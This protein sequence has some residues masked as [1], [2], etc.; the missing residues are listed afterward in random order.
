VKTSTTDPIHVDFLPPDRALALPERRGGDERPR[1]RSLA[2]RARGQEPILGPMAGT[3]DEKLVTQA[4]GRV[5]PDVLAA[6]EASLTEHRSE[7]FARLRDDV[8]QAWEDEVVG[9]EVA[10]TAGFEPVLQRLADLARVGVNRFEE[11]RLA[12]EASKRD[13][14]LLGVDLLGVMGRERDETAHTQVLASLI[15]RAP[16]SSRLLDR[17]GAAAGQSKIDTSK[18]KP[19]VLAEH[20]VRAGEADRRL[21]LLI[22]VGGEDDRL[23]VVVENKID[24]K[25]SEGQLDD[26]ASWA[27]SRS[28]QEPLLV[29]LTPRGDPPTMAQQ[30]GVWV[31]VSYMRLLEEWRR[32][33]RDEERTPGPWVEVLRLYLATLARH[34]C[35]VRLRPGASLSEQVRMIEYLRAATGG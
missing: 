23:V 32:V 25:D 30:A 24:A 29:Y 20:G 5:R 28:S 10:L 22:E 13:P 27:R 15:D 1:P 33:L 8:L 7:R 12:V 21:D 19:S 16:F 2:R 34:I 11:W 3:D 9:R 14:S 26:Y 31:P 35:G 6:H 17:L 4:F 18:G